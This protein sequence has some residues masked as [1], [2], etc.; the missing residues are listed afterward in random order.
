M[1]FM[2]IA[3]DQIL[4]ADRAGIA[5][6]LE[7]SGLRI[8]TGPHGNEIVTHD[9]DRLAFDGSWADLH[10]D[11]L[12]QSGPVTGHLSHATLSPEEC[13]FV[14]ALCAAGGFLVVNHQGGPLYVVPNRNHA[15]DDL[16]EHDDHDDVAWVD[17]ST[18]LALALAGVQEFRSFTRRVAG[19][20]S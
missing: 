4:D 12:D 11:P 5:Q 20:A 6:F 13:E 16:P 9:D 14:Y 3:P 10:L 19:P 18:E 2:R 7:R 15:P 17:S 1:S 8:V